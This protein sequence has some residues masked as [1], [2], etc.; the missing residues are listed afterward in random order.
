[1]IAIADYDGDGQMDVFV[2]NDTVRNFLFH[3]E[4]NGIF[5]ESGGAA[6]DALNADGRALSSMGADFRDVDN[7]GKP[8]LFVT[9]LTNETFAFYKNLGS[10]IFSDATYA[11]RLAVL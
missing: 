10:G 2:A 1:G 6:G 3:N 11:S 9:A 4:G 7:G 8:D 5:S